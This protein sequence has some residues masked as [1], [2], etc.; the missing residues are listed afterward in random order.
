MQQVNLYRKGSRKISLSFNSSI[1]VWISGVTALVFLL[2]YIEGVISITGLEGQVADLEAKKIDQTTRLEELKKE[3]EAHGEDPELAQAVESLSQEVRG[4]QRLLEELAPHLAGNTSG[5]SSHL[6]GLARQRIDGLWLRTIRVTRGGRRLELMGSTID[7]LTVPQLI[8]ALRSEPAFVGRH[9][10]S[11]LL[12]RSEEHD[13][14]VHF[15][16]S[17]H[18]EMGS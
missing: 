9:F 18:T 8:E 15:S 17:T 7:P 2:L 10:Q 4:K 6:R 11:F 12:E 3:A 14:I 1:I 16:M 13:E 5:F